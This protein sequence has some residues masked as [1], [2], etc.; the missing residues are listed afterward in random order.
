MTVVITIKQDKAIERKIIKDVAHYYFDKYGVVITK[1]TAK[2]PKHFFKQSTV[3][4][5]EEK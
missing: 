4:E 1:S 3:L 2:R 5:L